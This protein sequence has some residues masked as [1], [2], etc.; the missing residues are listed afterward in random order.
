MLLEYGFHA[1]VILIDTHKKDARRFNPH[2]ITAITDKPLDDKIKMII[3]NSLNY[4]IKY[5]RPHEFLNRSHFQIISNEGNIEESKTGDVEGF[6]IAWCFWFIE[7]KLNN[8]DISDKELIEYETNKI[9][10]KYKH[11]VNPF[12]HHIRNYANNIADINKNILE[13]IKI[14]KN[15]LYDIYHTEHNMLKISKYISKT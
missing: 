11:T 5:Y 7:I 10:T 13:K 9:I 6:C 8:P 4:N 3:E 15:H 1:N 14:N 12:K 2:G